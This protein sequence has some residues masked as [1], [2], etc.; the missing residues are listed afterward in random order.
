MQSL[1]GLDWTICIGYLAAV[2]ALGVWFA[3][4]QHSNEDY[5]VGGRKMHWL[6]IGL[7]VF[8]GTFSSNS[9]VGLP[10]EAAYED[11]H[12]LLGILFIPLVVMPIIGWLF[13][14]LFHRLG[15]TSAYEYLELRFSRP[16][17]LTASAL[18]IAY[19]IGWMGNMLLAVGKIL[20]VVLDLNSLQLIWALVAVGVFATLYTALGGV[21]AVVWTD[22]MQAFAL[23]AGMLALLFLAVGK[24]DGGW[25]A[26]VETGAAHRKFDM[27][28]V[29]WDFTEKNF[30][31]AC[32]FGFFVYLG[33]HAVNFTTVQRYVSMPSVRD[34]RRSL[35]VTS[36]MVTAVCV[37]FFLVG[38]TLFVFY[39]QNPNP[40]FQAGVESSKAGDLLL[41]H[42]VLTEVPEIGLI[43]LLLAGLFAA[44]MSS[45]DSGINSVTASVVCDWF[46]GRE[47]GLTVSR[48]LTVLFGA[49]IIAVATALLQIEAPIFE[50][51]IKIAGGFLGLLL[52]MFCLG[53][54]CSRA[55]TGG[56]LI[57]VVCGIAGLG[58][59][60]MSSI[61]G[62]WW[63]AVTTMTTVIVGFAASYL[64][65]KPTNN[66]AI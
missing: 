56:T 17:R 37:L 4:R 61:H 57:G 13:I 38:S 32:A 62:W 34:A 7:S 43:G 58:L 19:A 64:F 65:A 24:I 59:L 33:G 52:G 39:Q 6:P 5:F 66:S 12:L 48:S 8:A 54:F 28:R 35:V 18:F 41:P 60:R 20:K 9:F 10:R 15:V 36:V 26:V 27:F 53:M 3:R 42:F 2:L 45:M 31:A 63:G 14:P 46:A 22:A 55:N 1:G 44:A 40:A 29:E 16:V 25:S 11:Y 23:G 21:K 51:L 30:F 50:I 47:L 49:A